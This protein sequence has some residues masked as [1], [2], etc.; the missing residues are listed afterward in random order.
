MT[1]EDG[2]LCWRL[3]LVANSLTAWVGW[4]RATAAADGWRWH[5][6]AVPAWAGTV[7]ATAVGCGGRWA[8]LNALL[9]VGLGLLVWRFARRV[10]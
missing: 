8:A 10:S 5:W 6:L 1:F 2:S 4:S 9:S 3:L 7:A